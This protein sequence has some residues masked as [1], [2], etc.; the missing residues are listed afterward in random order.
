MEWDWKKITRRAVLVALVFV[1]GWVIRTFAAGE[2]TQMLRVQE[3]FI[4][5][6]E[7][8]N[9]KTVDAMICAD[10]VDEWGQDA[11]LLKED[12]RKL[13]GSFLFLSIESAVTDARTASGLGMVKTKL[14]I[15]G[16][17]AGLS[18]MVITEANRLKQP[19]VF[20]WHK[21]GRWPWSWELV[22]IDNPEVRYGRP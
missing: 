21:R 9:W 7:K 20:H 6:L 1:L 16:N 11:A 5:A 22:Q 14:K 12:M 18:T 19:W 10:Y 8:R 15:V 13:L 2:R 4:Q 17:G 3:Q